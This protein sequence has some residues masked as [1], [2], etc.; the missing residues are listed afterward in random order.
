MENVFKYNMFV[1]FIALVIIMLFG[2]VMFFEKTVM[3]V[4]ELVK[5]IDSGDVPF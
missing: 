4:D 3:N 1:I 5:H 2:Y